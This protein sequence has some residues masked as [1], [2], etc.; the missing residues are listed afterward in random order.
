[1][2]HSQVPQQKYVNVNFLQQ[3][4]YFFSF[5][6]STVAPLRQLSPPAQKDHS[7]Q[8]DDQQPLQ[9]TVTNLGNHNGNQPQQQP[10]TTVTNHNDR[11]HLRP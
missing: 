8:N 3:L 7:H 2:T 10:T 9:T 11:N 4:F 5:L 6:G 1:M